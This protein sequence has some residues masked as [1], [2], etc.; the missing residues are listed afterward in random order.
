MDNGQCVIWKKFHPSIWRVQFIFCFILQNPFLISNET[1]YAPYDIGLE[2]DLFIKWPEG[3]S[4]D[5]E[6]YEN[7]NLLAWVNVTIFYS[8]LNRIDKNDKM[9]LY[10]TRQGGHGTGA[11]HDA[12]SAV[13]EGFRL[14][15]LRVSM[16]VPR[17][18]ALPHKTGD[19]PLRV[20]HT[21]KMW[22]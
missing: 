2:R 1:N 10:L 11:A 14:L 18:T 19:C 22:F 5:Y 7:N 12:S 20:H 8:V 21:T 16:T 15:E 6:I 13:W 4:P 9:T 17:G 3:L